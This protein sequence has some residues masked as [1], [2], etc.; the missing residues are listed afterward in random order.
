[1]PRATSGIVRETDEGVSIGRGLE[2]GEIEVISKEMIA[3]VRE[4]IVPVRT[5][6]GRGAFEGDIVEEVVDGKTRSTK[7]L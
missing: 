4:S 3:S 7:M 6:I 2:N 5:T 1:M